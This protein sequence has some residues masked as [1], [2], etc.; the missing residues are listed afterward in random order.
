LKDG[1]F[2][3]FKRDLYFTNCFPNDQALIILTQSDT[4]R[5]FGEGKVFRIF[6]SFSD[7]FVVM[8][9][10]SKDRFVV[11]RDLKS[12]TVAEGQKLVDGDVVGIAAKEDLKFAPSVSV[13]KER[14][15]LNPRQYFNCQTQ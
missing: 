5:Y 7:R 14:E 9:K 2:K 12:T 8:I 4:V 15:P 11:Y 13:Y 1:E 6:N 10:V 3:E